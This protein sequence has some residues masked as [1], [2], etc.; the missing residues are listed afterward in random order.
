MNNDEEHLKGVASSFSNATEQTPGMSEWF[1]RE[2]KKSQIHPM[3]EKKKFL[4][5]PAHGDF[6]LKGISK[7][8]SSVK[9]RS[10]FH[11]GRSFFYILLN[12][13]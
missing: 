2:K 12:S 11:K 8:P 3:S 13:S 9:Y 10:F 4:W 6:K 7:V 5:Q 1:L